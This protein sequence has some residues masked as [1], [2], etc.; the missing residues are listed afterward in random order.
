MSTWAAVAVKEVA[1]TSSAGASL[2]HGFA[3][4]AI[5]GFA[6]GA[7][8]TGVCCLVIAAPRVLRRTRLTARDGMWGSGLRRGHKP[9]RDYFATPVD[10]DLGVLDADPALPEPEP[11]LFDA[12]P[13]L[14][15][16][17]L[18]PAAHLAAPVAAEPSLSSLATG[19][20]PMSSAAVTSAAVTSAAMSSAVIASTP[21]T[22][23]ASEPLTVAAF[24]PEAEALALPVAADPYLAPIGGNPYGSPADEDRFALDEDPFADDDDVILPGTGPDGDD[25]DSSGRSGYRSK[26]RL[27]I[28]DADRRAE[29]RRTPPRH[30]A[31]SAGLAGWMSGRI[32]ALPQLVR[33]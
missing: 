30:A 12:E 26:H 8:A 19:S 1:F 28:A 32:G 27:T 5:D 20:S 15:D 33:G 6:V 22:S 23:M 11:T 2:V 3:P 10:A 9:Q 21:M 4:G 18:A 25:E 31:P 13:A 14:F 17:D 24:A 7:L 29:A 16:A